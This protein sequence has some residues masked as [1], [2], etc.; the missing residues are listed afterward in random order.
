MPEARRSDP[1]QEQADGAT[2]DPI[3]LPRR[4]EARTWFP[5]STLAGAERPS[6]A[7]G[8]QKSESM[9]DQQLTYSIGL[10]APRTTERSI[11]LTLGSTHPLPT[12]LTEPSFSSQT[13]GPRASTSPLSTSTLEE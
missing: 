2:L 1:R 6:S 9:I 12:N 4:H 7:P 10:K 8:T 13:R 5:F 3:S 11:T